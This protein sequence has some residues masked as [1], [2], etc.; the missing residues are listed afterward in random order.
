RPRRPAYNISRMQDSLEEIT[1]SQ[2]LPSQLWNSCRNPTIRPLIRQFLYK[3]IQRAHRVG[4]YW[5]PITGYEMR[6]I[7][8]TCTDCAD[9]L[10]HILLE[11]TTPAREI[12]WLLTEDLWP[13]SFGKWPDL[14]FG[15]MLSCGKLAVTLDYSSPASKPHPGASR[16]LQILVS[17]AICL[18]WVL[19]CERVIQQKTHTV[20][21]IL[22]RWTNAIN[23]RLSIDHIVASKIKRSPKEIRKV[24][25]TW[26]H[27]LKNPD[28]L[29]E[30]WAARPEVLV[31]I[32]TPRTPTQRM[33]RALSRVLHSPAP[34]G[35]RA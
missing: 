19:R 22:S 21:T 18:L 2:E 6:A 20:K 33:L 32:R 7:C 27:I 31:G 10:D 1:H 29:P 11:C 12:V 13:S 25:N 4:D 17:E 3:A 15:A 23:R 34:A 14:N 26:T 8:P 5:L 28:S 16:L 30:N 35:G 24:T 9:N